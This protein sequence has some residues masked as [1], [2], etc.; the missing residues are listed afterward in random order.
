MENPI[1]EEENLKTSLLRRLENNFLEFE[2]VVF[3]K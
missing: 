1:F 3:G 2:K